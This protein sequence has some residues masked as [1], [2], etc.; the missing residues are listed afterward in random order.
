MNRSAG[1]VTV[2]SA[3]WCLCMLK[4]GR[5]GL[6]ECVPGGKWTGRKWRESPKN[7]FLLTAS[8]WSKKEKYLK[9]MK[10]IENNQRSLAIQKALLSRIDSDVELESALEM[11]GG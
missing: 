9:R 2:S 5:L 4:L 10:H 11:W 6:G 7:R 8:R 1:P 3:E